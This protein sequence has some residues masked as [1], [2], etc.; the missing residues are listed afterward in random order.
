[1]T[2]RE[3]Q[4]SIAERL[5]SIYDINEANSIAYLWL[6]ERLGL[7]RTDVM[8][9]RNTIDV[10]ATTLEEDIEQ[11]SKHYPIQYLVGRGD[12]YGRKF[13]LNPDTLI[14][15]SETEELVHKI[16]Q[17]HQQG[18]LIDIGTG[19]GCIPITIDLESDITCYGIDVNPKALEKAKLNAKEL[20]SKT[21]FLELNI[22]TAALEEFSDLDVIVSNPPYVTYAEKEIMDKN[23]VDFEPELALYVDD[24]NPLIFYKRI[25]L[26]AAEKLKKGGALY[27]EIN[28]QFGKETAQLLLDA[29]F[30]EVSITKDFQGKDRMVEG[31]WS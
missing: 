2:A 31:I 23:V 24:D 22:L 11:L 4:Q 6:E 20:E 12:F 16:L 14:P 28:E 17:K 19:S 5:S 25:T 27:F 3:I 21:K 13:H 9:D 10:S 7:N 30:K 18:V 1:M 29:G 15:R 26:L 8:L